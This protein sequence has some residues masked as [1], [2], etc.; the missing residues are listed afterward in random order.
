MWICVK[1][2]CALKI[3]GFWGVN[4]TVENSSESFGI[5]GG[6]PQGQNGRKSG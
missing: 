4:K 1:V 3:K 5:L 2:L 6:Y